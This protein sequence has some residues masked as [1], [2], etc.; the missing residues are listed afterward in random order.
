MIDVSHTSDVSGFSKSISSACSYFALA[1]RS[2]ISV[3][4]DAGD[5]HQHAHHENPHQ[6]LD[7][8]RG[9][10][11]LAAAS[12]SPWRSPSSRRPADTAA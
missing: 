4:R 10:R 1:T 12:C 3:G 8:D 9:G 5:D 2:L 6:Q 7:L 11:G